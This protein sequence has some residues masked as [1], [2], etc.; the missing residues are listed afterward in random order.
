MSWSQNIF[1][2]LADYSTIRDIWWTFISNLTFLRNSSV[3][4]L[5]FFSAIC[6]KTDS[7]ISLELL[8]T[9]T[10]VNSIKM[11]TITLRVSS[12]LKKKKIHV[13][14]FWIFFSK[15]FETRSSMSI[16]ICSEILFNIYLAIYLIFGSKLFLRISSMI[17]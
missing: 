17:P 9:I 14:S 7:F 5:D 13:S 11:P 4:H 3:M 16:G 10:L 2:I 1:S 8:W 15:S 12:E 6:S